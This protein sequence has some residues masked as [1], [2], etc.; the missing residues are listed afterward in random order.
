MKDFLQRTL[1]SLIAWSWITEEDRARK[2]HLRRTTE[3]QRVKES[4][5]L[6]AEVGEFL[7]QTKGRKLTP[8]EWAWYE[9]IRRREAML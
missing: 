1:D 9:S 7:D 8:E 3:A 2:E 6:D 4:Q 5:E